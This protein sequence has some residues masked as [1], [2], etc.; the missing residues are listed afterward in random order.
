[1]HQWRSSSGTYG[2]TNESRKTVPNWRVVE[3]HGLVQENGSHPWP[4]AVVSSSGLYF[5]SMDFREVGGVGAKIDTRPILL[6]KNCTKWNEILDYCSTTPKF[7]FLVK[8]ARYTNHFPILLGS[9]K[10][11]YCWVQFLFS[12][13]GSMRLIFSSH[14]A[15]FT[16]INAL[17]HASASHHCELQGVGTVYLLTFVRP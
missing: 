15:I 14:Y 10:I 5:S 8:V 4:F 16:Q 1:M 2:R 3:Q 7:V 17:V 11:R 13:M 9:P 12:R 6:D